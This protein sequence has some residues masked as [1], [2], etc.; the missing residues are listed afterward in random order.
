[1]RNNCLLQNKL[2]ESQMTAPELKRNDSYIAANAL[3]SEA[4]DTAFFTEQYHKAQLHISEARGKFY[5]RV[6]LLASGAIVLSFSFFAAIT[7]K[8]PL[9]HT[10]LV[11]FVA[12]IF[13]LACVLCCVFRNPPYH[14][15]ILHAYAFYFS[16][17][18]QRQKHRELVA[19]QHSDG[20]TNKDEQESELV[21]QVLHWDSKNK[22]L[23][24]KALQFHRHYRILEQGAL[25]FFLIGLCLLGLF[26]IKNVLANP[27]YMVK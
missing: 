16:D 20:A 4:D 2:C 17:S 26:T 7:A 1:M 19:I 25:T 8:V 23:A 13:L 14:K 22:E 18:M 21:K 27:H 3:T 5:D 12:W 6:T 15:Y 24:R 9:V 10:M 11:L